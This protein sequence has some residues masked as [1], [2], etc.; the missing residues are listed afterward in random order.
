MSS[1]KI[2]SKFQ[3]TIPKEVRNLLKLKSGDTIIFEIINNKTIVIKKA[4]PFD[5]Q[6]IKAVQQTLTEWDSKED[7]EDYK[8]LQDA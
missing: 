5:K 2:T 4:K 1:S 3:A 6:Y 7:D 8:H